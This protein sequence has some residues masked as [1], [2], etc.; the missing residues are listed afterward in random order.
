M[1]HTASKVLFVYVE[2]SPHNAGC[3]WLK[4]TSV[5]D[6]ARCGHDVRE[7][8]SSSVRCGN[9]KSISA[10]H[11]LPHSPPTCQ[12]PTEPRPYCDGWYVMVQGFGLANSL[13]SCA[14]R[15]LQARRCWLLSCF[16]DTFVPTSMCR[17]ASKILFVYVEQSPH[18]AG[19][20]WLKVTSVWDVARCGHDVMEVSSSSVRCGNIK[21]ISAQHSLPHSPPTCQYPTEPRPYCDG[22]F[23][24]WFRGLDLPTHYNHVQLGFCMR[25]VFVLESHSQGLLPHPYVAH[26]ISS[27]VGFAMD[28]QHTC[29][30]CWRVKSMS[31]GM[32]HD[33]AKARVSTSS[34]QGGNIKS[35]SAQLLLLHSQTPCPPPHEPSSLC[36]RCCHTF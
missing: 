36:G 26:C 4:V 11:S 20:C 9:I 32:L 27:I 21:S 8:S 34:L 5:W 22:W 19:C 28:S 23:W 12:Y 7:V 30:R 2:Q 1:Y 18:N 16:Q 29:T 17:T 15:V 31:I 25:G 6:V 14:I 10:Q 3:C 35:I 24:S 13:Q 33:V